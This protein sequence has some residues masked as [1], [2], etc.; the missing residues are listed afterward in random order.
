MKRFLSGLIVAVT[1]M[2]ACTISVKA[3]TLSVDKSNVRVGDTFTLTISNTNDRSEYE[4]DYNESLIEKRS[5]TGNYSN[6]SSVTGDGTVTFY[7]KNSGT[8]T[9]NFADKSEQDSTSP[10]TVTINATTTTQPPTTTTAPPTTTQAKS[11][12]ANLASLHV[13]DSD[14]NEV[15]LSP[16]FSSNTYEYSATVDATIRTINIDAT[17]ED[18]RANM[19]ISNNA[20]EELVAGENN[21]IT[22][23]VTA[24]DGTSKKAYVINIRREALTADAT[25]KSLSIKEC[26]DFEFEEDKF[27]YNVRVANSVTKLT[28]DYE[29]SSSDATVSISGNEDLENGSKVK[30]L[31]T[32]E[33]GTK[34]EYVLNIVK[35]NST[36]KRASSVVAEKNPLIIM[37]L[38]IVAFGLIGGIVYVIKK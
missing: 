5:H 29:A 12:N 28:I 18:S 9:F 30:I 34:R 27:S 15:E 20:T 1:L 37:A 21:R 4:L 7:A 33:D 10:I 8:V 13:T 36:T 26:D 3:A 19:V 31:V 23:T 38:S 24:E 11:T 6:V 17:M 22:I 35:E 14:G 32:A 16:S 2:F 25:L